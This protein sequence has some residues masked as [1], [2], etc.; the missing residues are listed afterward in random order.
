MLKD[1]APFATTNVDLPAS[2]A[3]RYTLTCGMGMMSGSLLVGGGAA[4]GTGS[5]LVWVLALLAVVGAVVVLSVRT[6]QKSAA[7]AEAGCFE[8][9]SEG[10]KLDASSNDGSLTLG[11][12][13]KGVIVVSALFVAAVIAGLSFGGM[14]AR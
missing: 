14:F 11:L 12:T 6:R 5:Q 4:T 9:R 13:P 10:R 3:G 2:K 7:P 8:G 1:L